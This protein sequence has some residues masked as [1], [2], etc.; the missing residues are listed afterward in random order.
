MLLSD[1]VRGKVNVVDK[2][3]YES[4]WVMSVGLNF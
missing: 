2:S 4:L 3:V 1:Y